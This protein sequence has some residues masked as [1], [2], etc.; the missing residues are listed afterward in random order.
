MVH[1]VSRKSVRSMKE[2]T[3]QLW[4]SLLLAGGS[5]FGVMDHLWNGQLFLIGPNI[6][7]DLALGAAITIGIFCVWGIAVMMDK[8]TAKRPIPSN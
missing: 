2:D 7:S 6:L 1:H 8:M 3:Y 5:F 4:L